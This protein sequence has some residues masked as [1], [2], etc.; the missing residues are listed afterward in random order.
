MS[1]DVLTRLYTSAKAHE[2]AARDAVS[3]QTAAWHKT[4][5]RDNWDAIAEIER[6]RRTAR[7]I[8]AMA[9]ANVP[10]EGALS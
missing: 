7:A 3:A 10:G 5:A 1:T 9:L 6:L 2:I 4:I 8:S